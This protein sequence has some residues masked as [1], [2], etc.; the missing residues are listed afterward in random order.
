MFI[1]EVKRPRRGFY[2]IKGK[3]KNGK[4]ICDAVVEIDYGKEKK[5]LTLPVS[6][7]GEIN[8]L[9]HIK[10]DARLLKVKIPAQPNAYL[11]HDLNIKRVGK[12]RAFYHIYRSIF[13]LLTSDAP[14]TRELRKKINFSFPE[15][16][17]KPFSV[18]RRLTE[19]KLSRLCARYKYHEWLNRFKIEQEKV[20]P[21]LPSYG[22]VSFLIVV[23]KK[24]SNLK[25]LKQT[26][27]SLSSQVYKNFSVKIVKDRYLNK[28]LY[29]SSE[30]F[31]IFLEEGD[32]LEPIA[33]SCFAKACHEKE[34]DIVY[35][36]NDFLKEGNRIN[37]F[38]KPDWSP[39]YVLEFDYIQ[40][41][42]A[43]K[44]S[45]LKGK[46]FKSNYTL[47]LEILKERRYA[48]IFHIPTLLGTKWAVPAPWSAEKI[49]ALKNFLGGKA[50]IEKDET[51]GH[52]RVKYLAGIFPKVSIVI[53][54]K[55]KYEFVSRCLYSLVENTSYPDYE[56]V[57]VDNGS[58]DSRVFKLYEKVSEK[59]SLKLLRRSGEFNFSRLVNEGVRHSEGDIICLLNNDIEII[60]ETWLEEMVRLSLRREVGVVGAKLLYPDGRI[61][62]GGVILGIWFGPNHAFKGYPSDAP[63]Y[64]NRLIT[65]Q[66]YLAVTAACMLFRRDVFEEVGGFDERLAVNFND[67]DFCLRVHERGYRILWT[68]RARLVHV[69]SGSR[70]Y[71]DDKAKEELSL[72]RKRWFSYI[73]RDPYYNPNLT[74]YRTDFSLGEP[75]LYCSE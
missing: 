17:F 61:Q 54:T 2:L 30:D 49:E 59:V 24:T 41:P 55:D 26:I 70:R 29:H 22:D 33:L 3:V 11:T 4:E 6:A 45:L 25:F 68:P 74:R 20:I 42:V 16:L 38:F 27:D 56:I 19:A 73:E 47:I 50:S 65:V 39:D 67:T 72:F 58:G 75:F 60:E 48:N 64:M 14:A 18:Y 43:F 36:D 53:P 28:I 13:P 31:V 51:L 37:P 52:F 66:N 44:R 40:M 15:L 46:E 71:I 21:N 34:A 5:S 69:E 62:H 9:C 57:I 1:K 63:G 7:G 23:F 8:F 12:L 35:A 10:K 32:T